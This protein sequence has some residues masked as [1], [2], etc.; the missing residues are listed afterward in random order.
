MN[1][2]ILALSA[3]LIVTVAASQ[4]PADQRLVVLDEDVWVTFYDLPSRRFRSIRDAFVRRDFSAVARDLDISISFISVEAGRAGPELEPA[5]SS[6]VAEMQAIRGN[7]TDEQLNASQLDVL[8]A[9]THW[10]LSQQY[11]VFAIEAKDLALNRNAGRYLM[12]S[13][14]HLER[15]VLWSNARITKDVVKSLDS[16]RDMAT[17]LQVSSAPE[18]VY[19]DKPWRLAAKTLIDVGKQIDRV[20]RIEESLPE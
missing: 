3:C 4:E 11:L 9:R 13:A 8:F 14:H 10:L 1:K 6:V 7:L 18:K 2:L 20:V 12:A 15:A 17:Q 19:K 16:I 5:L